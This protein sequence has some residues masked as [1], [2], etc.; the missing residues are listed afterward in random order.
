MTYTGKCQTT[1]A[2][3][4][5]PSETTTTVTVTPTST[6]TTRCS[7]HANGQTLSPGQAVVTS[8]GKSDLCNFTLCTKSCEIVK[9]TGKCHTTTAPT[10]TPSETATT[11]TVTPSSTETTRCFCHANGQ[12]FSP[13]EIVYNSQD[14]E[15]WCFY[16]LCAENC[17]IVK[18]MKP[19]EKTTSPQPTTQSPTPTT[20]SPE[21]C[22]ALHP[23]RA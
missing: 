5:T 8:V 13:G 7:C 15:G 21:G 12:V 19:C 10:T 2:P 23:P 20:V 9:Y 4:T 16:A 3:T 6:E 18:H 17:H 22:S 11:V 1:T 14:K